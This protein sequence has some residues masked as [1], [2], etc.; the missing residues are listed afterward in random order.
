MKFKTILLL[1]AMGVFMF[2]SITWAE[3][4]VLEI[5]QE[6]DTWI[7]QDTSRI[8]SYIDSCNQVTDDALKGSRHWQSTYDDLSFLLGVD[9]ATDAKLDN[10]GRY[11]FLMRITGQTQALF[12]ID[13]PMEFP[14][15]LTPNNWADMGINIGY[16]YPHPSGKYV[17]VATHQYGNENFDIYKFDR[18]GEFIPLL[19]DPAIQY[20]GL[21]FKNEDEFFIISNDRKTQTLVKYT[22][23]T[24]KIDTMYT[25]SG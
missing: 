19:V 22:I 6:A 24:G 18:D 1:V 12:Y 15:Q 8:L 2:C 16:Y 7:I 14:H 10:T 20:R 13:S 21:V 11:Y 3:P 17:L 23:S 25:E 4:R 5:L 9:L